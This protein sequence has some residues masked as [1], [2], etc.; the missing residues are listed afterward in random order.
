MIR[1]RTAPWCLAVGLPRQVS[2]TNARRAGRRSSATAARPIG[3]R[4]LEVALGTGEPPVIPPAGPGRC[5]LGTIDPV[6]LIQRGRGTRPDEAP[7][8]AVCACAA[9][10]ANSVPHGSTARRGKDEEVVVA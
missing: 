2:K 4:A 6:P 9:E 8:T 5:G 7:A 3:T 1:A 10:G